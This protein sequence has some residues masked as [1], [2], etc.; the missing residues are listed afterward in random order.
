MKKLLSHPLFASGLL[1]RLGLMAGVLP[2]ALTRWYLPFLAVSTAQLTLDPWA[3]WLSAGGDVAAFPYGYAMWFSFVPATVLA[4]LAGLP[5]QW[6]YGCTLLVADFALLVVLHRLVP[7]RQRLV[8]AVYW[9]SPIVILA[10]YGLGLNDVLPAA[11]LAWAMLHLRQRQLRLA[12]AL[13]AA[14]ISAKLSMVVALPF[15]AIYLYHNRALRQRQK[16]FVVGF[17]ASTLVLGLPFLYS[18]AGVQ[19][20]LGNPEMTKVYRLAVDLGGGVA[21]YVVPLMYLVMVYLAWRIRRLNFDLF[22]ASAGMAFLLIVLMTPGSPGWMVWSMP[23]LVM[24]Q[25]MSGRIAIA[26]VGAFSGLYVLSTLLTTPLHGVQSQVL[27]VGRAAS[28]LQTLMVGLGV[29]L[30]MR[31]GREAISRNDFF[32]LSRKP[33]VV[34]IAGDSGAGKDTFVE[35]ITGLFGTHSVV[36]LSG[37]DYHLWDRQK[38]MWQVMTHLNPMANDLEAY[39]NDVMALTDGKHIHSRHYDH[40]TG[41]MSRPVHLA[42]NDFIIA[43]GL[44][45]LYLASLRDC[46]SLKIFLNIDEDL[47]RHFKIQRDVSQRGHSLERVISALDKRE[48]DSAR[49]IRPQAGHADLVFSLQ[50]IHPRMLDGLAGGAPL[51]LKLVVKTKPGFNELALN[52]VL[53]GVCGLHV[54]LD[55]SDNGAQVQMCIEGETSAADIAQAAAMLCPRML[56]FLDTPPAWQDGMAGLMQLIALSHISQAL[57]KRFI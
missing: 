39:C 10:T 2:A 25:A 27:E 56:E 20:L 45:A 17:V 4:K 22:Q 46:Y 1:V 12:G 28:L 21:L 42:S 23:F 48:P 32:R 8:L 33:F 5:L 41:K 38:P 11:L 43:S 57:T 29:V 26:L 37:D 15:F 24:Y 55:T 6:A 53:V 54:D 35:S 50:P 13:C 3:L 34:G 44:H 9:W 49:F 30:A 16:Q 18:S 47:R 14:A 40:H 31:M 7:G 52:R 51:R 19:M 36:H